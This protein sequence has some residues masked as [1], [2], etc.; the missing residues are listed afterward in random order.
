MAGTTTRQGVT[1]SRNNSFNFIDSAS[2]PRL[3]GRKKLVLECRNTELYFEGERDEADSPGDKK[4][5]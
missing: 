2:L 1:P 4:L 3:T 5:K